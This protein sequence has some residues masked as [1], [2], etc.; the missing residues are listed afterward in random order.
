MDQG[1]TS[2]SRGSTTYIQ[3]SPYLT[4]VIPAFNERRTIDAAVHAVHSFIDSRYGP[5]ELIIA[6]DGS[7]DG[8]GAAADALRG[9]GLPLRVIRSERNKGKGHALRR[10]IA[11]STGRFVLITDARPGD[12]HPRSADPFRRPRGGGGHRGRVA[13]ASDVRLVRRQPPHRMYLGKAFNLIVQALLIPGI[14]DTQC[15]FKLFQGDR[16]SRPLRPL[17]CRW[18]RNRRGSA[19]RGGAR[20]LSDRRT[21]RR[22]GAHAGQQGSLGPD[23]LPDAARRSRDRISAACRFVRPYKLASICGY[24]GED[25]VGK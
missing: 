19:Q 15:G 3:M 4:V 8:T 2:L 1:A 6:D 17:R 11:A 22:V 16:G 24:C 23:A 14:R 10:G 25:A 18:V 12:P 21:P 7:T 9:A 13:R 5:Y 20:R